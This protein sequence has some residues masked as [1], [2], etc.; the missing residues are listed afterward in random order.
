VVTVGGLRT[1]VNDTLMLPVFIGHSFMNGF[2]YAGAGP[3]VFCTTQKI[4]TVEDTT[5]ALYFG[6]INN[7]NNSQ[8]IWGGAVQASLAYYVNPTWFLK[9]NYTCAFTG[10][11]TVNNATVFSPGV[12]NG[13]NGGT[14]ALSTREKLVTQE[15]ALSINKVFSL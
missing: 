5:S 9:L 4:S 14:L 6:T 13:L 7:M 3:S 2:V 1:N 15:V 11:Y 10:N 8:W 12:N